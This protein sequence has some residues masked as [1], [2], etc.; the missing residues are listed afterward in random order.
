MGR[1]KVI[2]REV[3]DM[4]TSLICLLAACL[5][6]VA[7]T[8]AW[9]IVTRHDLDDSDYIVPDADYPAIVTL[10]EPDDCSGTL[11]HE[12][13]LLTVAHCAD[14]L[15]PGDSLLVNGRA[16]QVAEV[17][18]HPSWNRRRDEYDIAL[19]RFT[20]PVR[21][22]EPLPIYRG[23]DE[24]GSV[25][26]L[27]GRGVHATGLQGERRA[28]SDGNLRQATNVV[29]AVNNHF[30]E[31]IFERPGENGITELEGVGVSGDSGGP[32]FIDVDGVPHIAGLN[33]YGEGGNGSRVGQYGSRDYQSRVS[34][35]L[36]WLDSVVDFPEPPSPEGFVRGDSDG[37][38]AAG[39]TD[40]VLVLDY[41]FRGGR[42]PACGKAADVDDDGDINVTDAVYLLNFLFL[43]RRSPP[44]PFSSC[45]ADPTD[46]GLSCETLPVN[47]RP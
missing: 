41:L 38:G 19:V 6:L 15:D 23:S 20:R 28:E 47:C 21:G 25:I 29:T 16:Y 37:D 40:A 12:S 33:S 36:G 22:V 45:G 4:K 3:R 18:K 31:I 26:T 1:L 17:I 35:Y 10:F 32:A 27:L 9:A 2:L 24:L 7:A 8:M 34:R 30:I 14:D 42:V 43:G 39:L 44:E 5:G 46:D 13:Y 11:V